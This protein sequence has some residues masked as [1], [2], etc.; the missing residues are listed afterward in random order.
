MDR[1]QITPSFRNK[2]LT[3]NVTHGPLLRVFTISLPHS[4]LPCH[5]CHPSGPSQN[6][7][8]D[9]LPYLSFAL[10]ATPSDINPLINSLAKPT[11]R[12]PCSHR[13][14]SS[15]LRFCITCK[16]SRS[17]Y[18]HAHISLPVFAA[19]LNFEDSASSTV[20]ICGDG[21]NVGL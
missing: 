16:H 2:H 17:H 10:T 5:C 11:Q 15:R 8:F 1:V 7:H 6:F 9:L 20:V 3:G 14:P 12:I 21:F 13:I 18:T 4:R 19:V